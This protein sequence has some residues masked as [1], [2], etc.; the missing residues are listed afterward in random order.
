M[1]RQAEQINQMGQ[2]IAQAQQQVAAVSQEAQNVVQQTQA[3]AAQVVQNTV[4][5]ATMATEME[6]NRASAI[7]NQAQQEILSANQQLQNTA[8]ANE[9][10]QNQLAEAMRRLSIQQKELAERAMA[11]SKKETNLNTPRRHVKHYM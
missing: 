7:A 4:A 5:Q 8:S 11:A 1:K 6:R 2:T 10:L 3:Q 9:Q